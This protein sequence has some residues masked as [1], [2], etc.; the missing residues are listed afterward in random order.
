MALAMLLTADLPIEFWG[1]AMLHACFLKNRLPHK[2]LDINRTPYEMWFG[3]KPDLKRLKVFGCTAFCILDNDQRKPFAARAKK[4]IYIGNDATSP[5]YLVY[6]PEEKKVLK[7][8]MAEFH[9]AFSKYGTL[10]KDQGQKVESLISDKI[11]LT[12]RDEI[13]KIDAILE[14][15]V[16]TD[17]DGDKLAVMLIKCGTK[18][19]FWAT[20]GNILTSKEAAS[21]TWRKV[22]NYLELQVDLDSHYPW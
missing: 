15:R 9:E 22:H 20:L 3:Q 7:W 4:G 12:K 2:G 8:G 14:H 18:N 13:P 16:Y 11:E 17:E 5:S 19:P 1:A 10:L 21:D 6:L